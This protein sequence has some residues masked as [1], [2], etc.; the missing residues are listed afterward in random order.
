MGEARRNMPYCVIGGCVLAA[1]VVLGIWRLVFIHHAQ[2]AEGI[3]YP[4]SVGGSHVNIEFVTA[5]GKKA[6]FTTGGEVDTYPGQRVQVL[7]QE[8]LDQ[9]WYPTGVNAC[10]AAPASLWYL[11]SRLFLLGGGFFVVGMWGA[12]IDRMVGALRRALPKRD[13]DPK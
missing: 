11:P 7:Y 2:S 5:S 6:T 10:M 9:R 3:V 1:A 13:H 8:G 4:L 12:S